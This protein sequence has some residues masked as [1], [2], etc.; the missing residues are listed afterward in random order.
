[1]VCQPERHAGEGDTA[2]NEEYWEEDARALVSF[3]ALIRGSVARLEV[4]LVQLLESGAEENQDEDRH[5]AKY[6]N[7]YETQKIIPEEES[8]IV[9]TSF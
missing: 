2:Q 1:M 9:S 5:E 7:G 3:H 8:R 6:S 4:F